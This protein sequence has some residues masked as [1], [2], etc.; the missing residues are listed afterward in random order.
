MLVCGAAGPGGGDSGVARQTLAS[1]SSST[2]ST[3]GSWG[4]SL[5]RSSTRCST[6]SWRILSGVCC[7]TGVGARAW[8]QCCGWR[9]PQ[10][11]TPDGAVGVQPCAE[12]QQHL[13]QA[14]NVDGLGAG[15]V[16]G[17]GWRPGALPA[18]LLPRL[19]WSLP[20]TWRRQMPA[21]QPPWCQRNC[22]PRWVPPRPPSDQCG[23]LCD[24]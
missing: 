12:P 18:R 2:C 17:P 5:G 22:P 4:G 11:H 7:T 15:G 13:R 14:V 21:D 6:W 20:C 8:V 23:R 1:V 24:R 19:P 9:A 10:P 16:R 3:S